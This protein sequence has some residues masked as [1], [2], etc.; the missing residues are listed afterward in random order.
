M[1]LILTSNLVTYR[2]AIF[3]FSH[4][5]D[6]RCTPIRSS[7]AL[8]QD[9]LSPFSSFSYCLLPLPFS[10]SLASSATSLLPTPLHSHP[11]LL[12]GITLCTTNKSHLNPCATWYWFKLSATVSSQ[13]RNGNDTPTASIYFYQISAHENASTRSSMGNSSVGTHMYRK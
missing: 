10:P 12:S 8:P 11:H 5:L 9:S 13:T 4:A 6:W 1:A 2:F 3:R 7:F